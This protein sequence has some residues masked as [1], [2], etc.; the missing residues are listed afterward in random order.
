MLFEDRHVL[1]G[2]GME[3]HLG[4]MF[5]E[6]VQH[7]FAIAHVRQDRRRAAG[8]ERHEQVVQVRLVVV[9]EREARRLE[10]ADLARDLGPIDP[11]AP[12]IRTRLP[13]RS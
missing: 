6:H 2:G 13:R 7:A 5:A 11:P 8:A 1:V 12:V 9:E 10:V 3:H 4:P